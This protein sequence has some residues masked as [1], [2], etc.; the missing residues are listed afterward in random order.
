VYKVKEKFIKRKL[1]KMEERNR[2]EKEFCMRA[3][4]DSEM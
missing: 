3:C 2:K 4:C 1:K